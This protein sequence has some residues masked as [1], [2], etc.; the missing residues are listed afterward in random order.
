MYKAGCLTTGVRYQVS[1]N[2]GYHLMLACCDALQRR[3]APRFDRRF[4]VHTDHYRPI[5]EE[6]VDTLIFFP[7]LSIPSLYNML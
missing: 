2:L 4:I 3:L 7:I 6:E 1:V 5:A